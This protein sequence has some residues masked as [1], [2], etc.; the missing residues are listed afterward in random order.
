[1]PK[2]GLGMLVLLATAVFI[3]PKI[4]GGLRDVLTKSM[5]SM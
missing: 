5:D 2:E 3:D 1:M 4:A